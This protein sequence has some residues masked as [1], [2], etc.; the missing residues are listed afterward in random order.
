MVGANLKAE[1][2]ALMEKRVA[3]ETEMNSIVGRLCNPGGPGL[4]GNLVDSEGFP[5]ED[6]DIPVVRAERRRLAELRS[7]HS[8]ITDKISAN[9]QILHSVRPTSRA[10]STK[11]SGPE[12]S[13]SSGEVTSLSASMQT[14]GFSVTSRAMDVDVVT[15]IPFAMVDEINESSPAAEDGLQLGDQVVKFGNVEGGDNLLQR[16]AAEAQSSQG[17]AVSVG[18]IRQGAK[19]DLSVT[20]RIWQGRGLLGYLLI[21][22]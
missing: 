21:L 7:E 22:R 6:I 5:R 16:L 13:I 1:T 11:D 17:Q 3:M 12:A 8:E 20:P 14:G 9:I 15:C 4:S 18:V 2:M 19:V 10:S